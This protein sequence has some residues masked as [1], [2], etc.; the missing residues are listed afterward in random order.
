MRISD[1]SSDVCSS[2]LMWPRRAWVAV[3]EPRIRAVAGLG[4][5]PDAPDPDRYAQ[6]YAHCEV[7]V[8]G[9]G[10]ARP[11]AALAATAG[12]GRVILCDDR[13]RKGGPLLP[14]SKAT[15]DGED[16]A[17]GSAHV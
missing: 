5:T 17:I 10:P 7:L 12:G 13:P 4:V 3:Y 1:W 15:N 11:A 9:A 8:V 2:D 6:R 16:A 14:P